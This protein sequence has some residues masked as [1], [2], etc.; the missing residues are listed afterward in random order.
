MNHDSD[1]AV[2]NEPAY[3]AGE[4]NCTACAELDALKRELAA[5]KQ[6]IDDSCAVMESMPGCT[7]SFGATK[8][9][10]LE[11]VAELLEASA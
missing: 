2:H 9:Q 11:R 6:A 10:I 7:V 8:E 1:C 3:P 5:Y 4:C